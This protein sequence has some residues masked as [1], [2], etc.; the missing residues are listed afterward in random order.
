[1]LTGDKMETAQ[2]IGISAGIK[3]PSQDLFFIKEVERGEDIDEILNELEKA[4]IHKLVIVI[5][6][7]SLRSATENG[8]K[9][10]FKVMEKAPA[11]YLLMILLINLHGLAPL[12]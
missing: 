6:G 10:F 11:V 8:G 7:T 9:R 3:H 4:E 5:D 1:M 12:P 2:C